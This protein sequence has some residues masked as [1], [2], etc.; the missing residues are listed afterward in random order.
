MSTAASLFLGTAAPSKQCVTLRRLLESGTIL[1]PETGY[2][3]AV[4]FCNALSQHLFEIVGGRSVRTPCRSVGTE[5]I[6]SNVSF[7]RWSGA[8]PSSSSL[9]T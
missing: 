8:P 9:V 5:A 3:F 4:S 1:V 2:P 7:S 6:E